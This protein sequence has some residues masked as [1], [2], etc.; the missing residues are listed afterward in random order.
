MK[1]G[2]G[3]RQWGPGEADVVRVRLSRF[4]VDQAKARM[5][6]RS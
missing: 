6:K 1:S 5:T 4:L 3:L 2:E